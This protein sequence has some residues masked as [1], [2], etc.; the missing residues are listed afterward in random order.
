MDY[1]PFTLEGNFLAAA[2]VHEM[3]LQSWAARPGTGGWGAI[4]IFP[5]MPWA[6]HEAG[7]TDLVAEGG[8]KVSARREHNVTTWFRIV[9]GA[10]GEL[11]IR[12]NFGGRVLQWSGATPRKEGDDYVLT[13]Q[14]GEVI[15]ADLEKPAA[16]PPRPPAPP[17]PA[18]HWD[19][20]VPLAPKHPGYRMMP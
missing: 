8:H 10:A 3:L 20:D 16:L 13:V 9:A 12:D 15:E 18:D 14:A 5:A 11:R 19:G 1:R 2:A 7:F 6:W 17:A 4:R